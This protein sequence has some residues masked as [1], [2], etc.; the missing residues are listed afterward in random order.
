MSISYR[1]LQKWSFCRAVTSCP[2][3]RKRRLKRELT[4]TNFKCSRPI[5]VSS[6]S[7]LPSLCYYPYP[8]PLPMLHDEP[9]HNRPNETVLTI[10]PQLPAAVQQG[11]QIKRLRNPGQNNSN[12]PSWNVLQIAPCLIK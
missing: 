9:F 7:L 5:P 12:T 6:L 4:V 1:W 3:H 8:Y 11:S 10:P 2:L